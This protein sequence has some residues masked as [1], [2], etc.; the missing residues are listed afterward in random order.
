MLQH[1]P[2]AWS[3]GSCL[4]Y[5]TSSGICHKGTCQ[6]LLVS[7]SFDRMHSGLGWSGSDWNGKWS[8]RWSWCSCTCTDCLCKEWNGA[9]VTVHCSSNVCLF[10]GCADS[11]TSGCSVCQ[12][13]NSS[14]SFT[15]V[16]VSRK[17]ESG[18]LCRYLMIVLNT[19]GIFRYCMHG[20]VLQP[21]HVV[22]VLM[23]MLRLMSMVRLSY[24]DWCDTAFSCSNVL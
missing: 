10:V 20:T 21:F 2:S 24:I 17:R 23:S 3:V 16:L 1:P 19:H 12:R 22:A 14:S 18:L 7:T 5:V 4:P 8:Q 11:R 6:L 13:S 9:S 15:F